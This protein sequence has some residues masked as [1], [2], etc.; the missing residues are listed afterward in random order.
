MRESLVGGTRLQSNNEQ[1]FDRA[2]INVS[3]VHYDTQPDRE[4]ASATA[5][6]TIIHP[7]HPLAPSVHIHFSHTEMRDGRGYWRMMADLNPSN[8]N[9]SHRQRFQEILAQHAGSYYEEGAANGDKYFHIPA[10]KRYRGVTHFYLEGFDTGNFDADFNMAQTLCEAAMSCYVS[11]VGEVLESS[12]EATEKEKKN[13]LAYHTLYLF[14]VLTLDRGT[15]SG[16]MVHN[17]NDVGIMGSIP[18]HV[19]RDLLLSWK[20]NVPS[21]QEKL[22]QALVDALP[23]N[24]PAYVSDQVKSQLATA[25]RTHYKTYPEALNLQASGSV[26]PPTVQNHQK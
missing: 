21:P 18:S 1:L 9:E 20:G 13:Q 3:Q 12:Q 2:S 19:D 11:L 4:L 17:E 26:V 22:V 8:V 14:Q 5:I 7:K 24:N 23:S 25:V 10:L 15:T 16:L 6:S